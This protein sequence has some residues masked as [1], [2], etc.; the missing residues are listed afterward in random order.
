[1]ESARLSLIIV[2]NNCGRLVVMPDCC[3]VLAFIWPDS[4]RSENF[5]HAD[6]GIPYFDGENPRFLEKSG[7]VDLSRLDRVP[8]DLVDLD[9]LCSTLHRAPLG[10][11]AASDIGSTGSGCR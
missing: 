11:T 5:V 10:Q 6:G 9:S 7:A 2:V 8:R 1:M 3:I 4:S